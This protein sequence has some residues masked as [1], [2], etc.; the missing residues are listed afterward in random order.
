MKTLEEKSR[1]NSVLGEDSCS[2]RL[3]EINTSI[4]EEYHHS[5]FFKYCPR[6]LQN[7]HDFILG[8]GKL[9]RLEDLYLI[10]GLVL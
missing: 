9:S 4:Y 2:V 3:L 8:K 6:S 5:S 10:E 1:S 7:F